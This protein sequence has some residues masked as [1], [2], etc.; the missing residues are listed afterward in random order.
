MLVHPE[1]MDSEQPT[2]E[3]LKL[4]IQAQYSITAIGIVAIFGLAGILITI[5]W[6]VVTRPARKMVYDAKKQKDTIKKEQEEL[7]KAFYYEIQMLKGDKE[8]L[9]AITSVNAHNW[10]GVVIRSIRAIV[11]YTK[12]GNIQYIKKM[13]SL[14]ESGL[15]NINAITMEHRMFLLNRLNFIPDKFKDKREEIRELINKLPEKQIKE[16]K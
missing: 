13:I 1:I 8:R 6:F 12:I 16:E 7:I 9:F 15:R 3:I 5:N 11:T 10:E 2:W 14:L 4:I